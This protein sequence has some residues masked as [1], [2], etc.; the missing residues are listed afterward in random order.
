MDENNIENKAVSV[1]DQKDQ[2]FKRLVLGMIGALG[3]LCL[4]LLIISGNLNSYR[5]KIQNKDF[6]SNTTT[7][8]S[9]ASTDYASAE[10]IENKGKDLVSNFYSSCIDKLSEMRENGDSFDIVDQ[11]VFYLKKKNK[12][13][14]IFATHAESDDNLTY[15]IFIS[16]SKIG[17]DV[18]SV[19]AE[20]YEFQNSDYDSDDP[21]G[22]NSN[23]QWTGDGFCNMETLIDKI[24]KKNGNDTEEIDLSKAGVELEY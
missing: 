7:D 13:I 6:S 1:L 15:Y 16:D 12:L 22:Y 14:G 17:T 3:V 19:S 18:E 2:S 9:E 24:N 5:T 23:N 8:S 10:E 4:I 20:S 11:R 21:T